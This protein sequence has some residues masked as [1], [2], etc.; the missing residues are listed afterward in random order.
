MLRFFRANFLSV[1]ALL[2]AATLRGQTNE[3][4]LTRFEFSELHMGTLFRIVLYAPEAGAATQASRAAFDRVA[5]LDDAMS[6]YRSSSELMRLCRQAGGPPVKVRDDLFQVMAAA[7]DISRRSDGAF[8]VSVGPVVRLWRGA[9]RSHRL[10]DPQ[11]LAQATKRVGYQR[12]RLDSNAQ[13]VQLLEPGM[14]LDLGGIAKGYASDAAL[15]VLRQQGITRALVAGGGDI[16]VGDPPPGKEGWR[17]GIAPL[18]SPSSPPR[19]FVLLH[20]NAISTSGESEQHVE[21]EGVR[22]SHIVDPH[23][24]QALTGRRSATVIAPNCTTSDALA[25]AVCVLGPKRGGVL[26]DSMPGTSV[27]IVIEEQGSPHSYESK[28][29][30]P[31]PP[32]PVR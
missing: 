32:D 4:K 31:A 17:I 1:A 14:L 23:T 24:G 2:I 29:P 18:E 19:R 11:R 28:F 12:I 22:Y 8:D 6:D 3:L 7:Q 30:P 25:T 9:R 15:A 27:L 20:N 26:I 10:P 21:I 13:T 16:A 5:A